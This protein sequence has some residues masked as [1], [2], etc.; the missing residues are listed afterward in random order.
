MLLARGLQSDRKKLIIVLKSIN[1]YRLSGYLCL[2][3]EKE[4][5][6]FKK[7][8]N[9]AQ[10]L[11]IYEFDKSL[12]FLLFEGLK[13]IEVYFKT[14]VAYCFS[15]KF[16]CFEY[17]NEENFPKMT[18]KEFKSFFLRVKRETDRSKEVFVTHFFEKYGRFH[19]ILPIWMAVELFSFG[20][21]SLFFEGLDNS[22]KREIAS[23]F[24]VHHLVLTSWMKNFCYVRNLCAH[25]SRLWN[26]K[27]AIR[28]KIPKNCKDWRDS[29]FRN[30]K[31]FLTILLMKMI[32][33]K[34]DFSSDWSD[35]MKKMLVEG[36]EFLEKM[37]FP[38]DWR[39]YF[40]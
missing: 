37:G 28:P 39:E 17:E 31:I 10:I 8:T 5:N 19:K 25:H 1:Y 14:T 26:R 34:I 12:R 20:S 30:D 3:R 9:L 15:H 4:S 40:A 27:L 6:F 24:G 23:S 2:F 18:K 13:K 33:D 11:K 36:E 29:G 38:S 22:L 32:V 7:N 16:G 21:I 35:K